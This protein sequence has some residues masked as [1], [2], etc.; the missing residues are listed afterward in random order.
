MTPRRNVYKLDVYSSARDSFKS[1]AQ[2]T[3]RRACKFADNAYCDRGHPLVTPLPAGTSAS[4]TENRCS[5]DRLLAQMEKENRRSSIVCYTYDLSSRSLKCFF[6][7]GFSHGPR[8]VPITQA[9]HGCK[10]ERALRRTAAVCRCIIRE[11]TR[12]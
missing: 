2:P 8:V 5:R 3:F 7:R 9:L 1:P 11:E 6:P 10:R 12:V 4:F